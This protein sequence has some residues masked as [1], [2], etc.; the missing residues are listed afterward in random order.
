MS[1]FCLNLIK[2]YT[3]PPSNWTNSK[4]N[5]LHYWVSQV[6][7]RGEHWRRLCIFTP[8]TTDKFTLVL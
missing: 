7:H 6:L 4:L 3:E 5:L 2:F 1:L 8:V